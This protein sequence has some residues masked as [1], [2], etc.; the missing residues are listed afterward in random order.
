VLRRLFYFYPD[1]R[2]DGRDDV[3]GIGDGAFV[4]E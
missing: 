2:A 4:G 1:G 3:V